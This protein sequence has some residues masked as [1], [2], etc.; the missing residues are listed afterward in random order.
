MSNP[1]LQLLKPLTSNNY[2]SPILPQTQ[3]PEP[4]LQKPTEDS[5][6]TQSPNDLTELLNQVN[7]NLL[8]V[9]DK[10]KKNSKNTYFKITQS[11]LHTDILPLYPDLPQDRIDL[12]YSNGDE[13]FLN[14]KNK[15]HL[16]N[17]K[18]FLKFINYLL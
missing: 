2:P 8:R 13:Y 9:L 12:I 1:Y 10:K 6:K 16:L 4:S 17:K 18:N 14:I 3:L 5:V 11:M 15:K 7:N